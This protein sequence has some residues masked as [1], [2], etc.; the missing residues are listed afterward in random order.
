MHD[1]SL[2]PAID[3][4]QSMKDV[5]QPEIN[6]SYKFGA[7]GKHP[8]QVQEVAQAQGQ[9]QQQQQAASGQEPPQLPR[10]KL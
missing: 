2:T 5:A 6:V 7:D 3:F 1:R 10:S 8:P 9:Q 4:T